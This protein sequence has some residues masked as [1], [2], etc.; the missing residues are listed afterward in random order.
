T[1][2]VDDVKENTDAAK[3]LGIHVWN[4]NPTTDNVTELFQ[5]NSHLF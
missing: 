4:L 3:S 1:L 2:F 5:K